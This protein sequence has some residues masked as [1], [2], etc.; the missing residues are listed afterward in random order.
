MAAELQGLR[1]EI[2]GRILTV[3]LKKQK[4]LLK[5]R[6]EVF[7]AYKRSSNFSEKEKPS[8]QAETVNVAGKIME[9]GSD[10]LELELAFSDVLSYLSVSRKHNQLTSHPMECV[11]KY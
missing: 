6:P 5:V 10:L 4:Q 2:A 8:Y 11:L 9:V 1:D 7:I 3:D